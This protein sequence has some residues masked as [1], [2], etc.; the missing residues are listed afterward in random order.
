MRIVAG[1]EFQCMTDYIMKCKISTVSVQ[2]IPKSHGLIV[3]SS[4]WVMEERSGQTGHL[5]FIAKG[6]GD[7][8]ILNGK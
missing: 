1:Q 8:T 3:N 2:N 4:I 5:N 7:L 6:Y